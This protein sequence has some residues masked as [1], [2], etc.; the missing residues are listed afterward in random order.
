[1]TPH[2]LLH[3]P[4]PLDKTQHHTHSTPHLPTAPAPASTFRRQLPLKRTS[5]TDIDGI[6]VTRLQSYLTQTEVT[7]AL[8]F[9]SHARG[10]ATLTS[11]VDIALHF[12][13]RGCP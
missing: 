1:M 10:T 9:G 7:F 2:S 3:E 12:P 13:D 5:G 11:D 4:T 8:L 6:D